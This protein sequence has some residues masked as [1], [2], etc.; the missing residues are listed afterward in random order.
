MC[1]FLRRHQDFPFPWKWGKATL[2]M[3]SRLSLTSQWPS[4]KYNI[5]ISTSRLEN[6]IKELFQV[7]LNKNKFEWWWLWWVMCWRVIFS[8]ADLQQGPSMRV[9][10]TLLSYNL[11]AVA[12]LTDQQCGRSPLVLGKSKADRNLHNI[13]TEILSVNSDL[14]RL[15]KLCFHRLHH[16]Y[17][18]MSGHTLVISSTV[19]QLWWF[20]DIGEWSFPAPSLAAFASS[21]DTMLIAVSVRLPP[22]LRELMFLNPC[23][24]VFAFSC[25]VYGNSWK[26][27]YGP[28]GCEDALWVHSCPLIH[29][30]GKYEWPCSLA[31]RKWEYVRKK[32]QTK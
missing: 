10:F 6:Y 7:G 11:G 24:N 14:E 27:R 32:N 1:H 30:G 9:W 2:Q 17:Q 20:F 13:N 25:Q 21:P 5:L 31:Q 29:P 28:C 15:R 8:V 23:R 22:S 26:L 18:L 19:T 4:S 12:L 3:Y 16:L